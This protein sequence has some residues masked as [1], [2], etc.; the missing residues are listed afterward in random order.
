MDFHHIIEEGDGRL[1]L[2][3][4]N[5]NDIIYINNKYIDPQQ[6]GINNSIQNIKIKRGS[7]VLYN[8]DNI[9]DSHI[10]FNIDSFNYQ[11]PSGQNCIP[12][13]LYL[14]ITSPEGDQIFVRYLDDDGE[15]IDIDLNNENIYPLEIINQLTN[16]KNIYISIQ[17][18]SGVAFTT[19]KFE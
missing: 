4:I 6:G 14:D 1:N 16:N 2:N 10:N 13:N 12:S 5:W 15:L 19:L 8:F 18:P 11:C 9:N 3:N 17:R 7:Q